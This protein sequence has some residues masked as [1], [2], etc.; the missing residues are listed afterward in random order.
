MAEVSTA[1]IAKA[2]DRNFGTSK[3]DIEFYAQTGGAAASTAACIAVAPATGGVSALASPLCGEI[4]GAVAKVFTGI[5]HDIGKSLFGTTDPNA[6][7]DARAAQ[8]RLWTPLR[9]AYQ[10]FMSK[11]VHLYDIPVIKGQQDFKF[12]A[13][14]SD[15]IGREL[16]EK[17]NKILIAKNLQPAFKK[18]G[19]G[20]VDA[21]T[22]YHA[23]TYTQLHPVGLNSAYAHNVAMAFLD[24]ANDTY[25]NRLKYVTAEKRKKMTKRTPPHLQTS[26]SFKP[27][28]RKAPPHLQSSKTYVPPPGPAAPAVT[29]KKDHSRSLGTAGG[30]AV[31]FAVGGPIGAGVGAALGFGSGYLWREHKIKKGLIVT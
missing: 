14:M 24:A 20:L 25:S 30:A 13:R 31:G 17:A 19:T 7:R 27:V 6:E 4:G 11:A 16:A 29:P 15:S 2:S 8:G 10:N 12:I 22:T 1:I 23:P 5:V 26:G 18:D 28:A 21:V 9:I 3:E